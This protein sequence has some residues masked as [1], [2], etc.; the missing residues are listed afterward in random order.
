M[1]DALTELDRQ[2]LGREILPQ[3]RGARGRRLPRRDA[4]EL[5]RGEG[6]EVADDLAELTE[7]RRT[8]LLRDGQSGESREGLEVVDIQSG[9]GTSRP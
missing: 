5:D 3:R 4:V 9:H 1:G 7:Q 8:V 2:R 6:V